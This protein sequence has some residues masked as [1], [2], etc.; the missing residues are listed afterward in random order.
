MIHKIKLIPVS[1]NSIK[2][3]FIPKFAFHVAQFDGFSN[4]KG[5]VKQSPELIEI[6]NE[7]L[8]TMEIDIPTEEPKPRLDQMSLGV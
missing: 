7:H 6:L 8:K 5:F 1:E 4:H 2:A 3:G